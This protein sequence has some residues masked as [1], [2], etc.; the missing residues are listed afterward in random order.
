LYAYLGI[1]CL[2]KLVIFTGLEIASKSDGIYVFDEMELQD[3]IPNW[4]GSFL[5]YY[6]LGNYID[7]FGQSN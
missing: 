1:Y 7:F 4:N 6:F 3:G 2:K 5:T